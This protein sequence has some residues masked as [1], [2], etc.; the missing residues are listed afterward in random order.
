M[1]A[2]TCE[3]GKLARIAHGAYRMAGTPASHLDDLEAAW[4]LT[5]PAKMSHERMAVD[6]W[7]G[8]AIAGTTAAS[9]L[10]IG[11]FHLTPYRIL[12][13]RRINS[14]NPDTRFGV[15]DIA[16]EDV[17]FREGL[18]VTRIERTLLDLSLD[19][20]EPSL[21]Q[22]A[23]ADARRQGLDEELLERL[24][25]ETQPGKKA[26]RLMAEVFGKD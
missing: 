4:K 24:V 14:R 3:A 10:G 18:P 22:D 23:L 11:D 8:I 15:R 13:P 1:L 5:A 21:V 6:A 25:F 12:A 26:D 20:E 17:T 2:K 19:N 9:L 16:R 7:D